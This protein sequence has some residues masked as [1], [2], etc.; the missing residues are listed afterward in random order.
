MVIA[1]VQDINT[2]GDMARFG[3]AVF[4][5]LVPIQ[6]AMMLFFS[7]VQAVSAVSQEKDKKTLDLLLLTRMTNYELVVGKLF[8]SM[9]SVFS[10]LVA[11]L[12]VFF[13]LTWLG[14]IS[15]GQVLTVFVLTLFCS[16]VAGSLGTLFGYWREKTFQ[17][18][19]LTTMTLVAWLGLGEIV[20]SGSFDPLLKQIGVHFSG[21]VLAIWVSPIRS[22]AIAVDIYQQR[23]L[24]TLGSPLNIHLLV[25]VLVSAWITAFTIWRVRVWNPAKQAR[26]I[27]KE[28]SANSDSQK[29]AEEAREGHIDS[30]LRKTGT[31][32]PTKSKTVWDNPV[33]WREIC[34]WAYG[35]KII[36]IRAT[37]LLFFCAVLY[38]I[39][40]QIRVDEVTTLGQSTFSATIPPLTKLLVPFFLLSFVLVNA[41]AVSSI[42]NER[43]N[44]CLDLLLATD[45]SPKEFLFGK[46]GGVCWVTKEM[47]VLPMLLIFY[48]WFE[49]QINTE[50]LGFLTLGTIVLNLFGIVLGIH[51]G[52]HYANSR[53]AMLI[54]LSLMFF[55][56]LGISTCIYMLV[57]FHASFQSQ[58]TPFLA[59]ILGG[60]VGIYIALGGRSP[61]AALSIASLLLPFATFYAI[62]SFLIGHNLPVF[63]IVSTAY[64]FA[65]IAMLIPAMS[66]YN[67]AM[68]KE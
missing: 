42:T 24:L 25:M 11:G 27:E 18:L 59:F 68:H 57:S 36:A 52:I 29:G 47:L 6:L 58:L 23:S 34:T 22:T 60:G 50:N 56:F 46:M 41:L 17:G 16:L 19:S 37:Y 31:K 5:I 4:Q 49:G 55:L 33:L 30:S 10:M 28:V 63:L 61:S 43:D 40:G 51:C 53:S 64:G 21:S 38:A 12:P 1:G 3:S 65:S 32:E 48:L 9:L 54:S 2:V 45:L 66:E 39:Y 26:P 15:L 8:G 13:F 20:A 35:R 7:A 44:H 14:G 67:F 62:T